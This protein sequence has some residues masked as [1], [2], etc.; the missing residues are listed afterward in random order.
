ML[1]A[2]VPAV[3]HASIVL[4]HYLQPSC[5][6]GRSQRTHVSAVPKVLASR[7]FLPLRPPSAPHL[8]ADNATVYEFYADPGARELYR[9]HLIKVITRVNTYTG[10]QYR[11][12]RASPGAVRPQPVRACEDFSVALPPTIPMPSTLFT[13]TIGARLY[14]ASAQDCRSARSFPFLVYGRKRNAIL[15]CADRMP[16]FSPP[17]TVANHIASSYSPPR[18]ADPVIMMY[19]VMNEPRCPGARRLRTACARG[20]LHHSKHASK[21]HV[22]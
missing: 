10:V 6:P 8:L 1:A 18:S 17:P 3:K 4:P 19:D 11:W 14:D 7:R 16:S 22:L 2:G 5:Q 13:T 20:R 21:G 9:Q 12:A 15:Q